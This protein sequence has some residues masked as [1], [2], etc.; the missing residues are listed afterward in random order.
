METKQQL[1]ERR[2]EDDLIK[3]RRFGVPDAATIEALRS[4]LATTTEGSPRHEAIRRFL[5]ENGN[6]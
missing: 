3:F 1:F 5:I 2:V 6:A 4:H